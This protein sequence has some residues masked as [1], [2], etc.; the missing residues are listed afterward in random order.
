M[1][2]RFNY[3]SR[4]T[5]IVTI[6]IV[7]LL[8]LSA[9]GV[10][11]F[12]KGNDNAEAF[13]EN[14]TV[15]DG[16]SQAGSEENQTTQ[17]DEQ[18]IQPNID[19]QN[20]TTTENNE[21]GTT[22]N[23]TQNTT[24]QGT[25]NVSGGTT[26]STTA[27]TVPNNE[28]VT[29]RQEEVERLVAEDYLVGWTPISLAAI[30][31]NIE[32]N[33]DE[34]V[35][36][37]EI[38]KVAT[39]VN[40]E[41]IVKDEN[42]K[43]ETK[44]QKGDK[45]TYTITIRNTGNV[46]LQDINIS[47]E[48][49]NYSET[50]K[51]LA[52]GD[53]IV[54]TVE[55]TV[56]EQDMNEDEEIVN[57]V[58][59]T[60][61][62]QT[63]PDKTI[64]K[65][66]E[67]IVPVNPYI[68]VSG[69]KTWVDYDNKEN[70]RPETITVEILNG[71]DVVDTITVTAENGWKYTSKELPKY[72]AENNVIN[73][74]VREQSVDKYTTTVNDKNITNTLNYVPM[75]TISGE[76]T[77]VD[78]NNQENTRPEKITIEVLNGEKVV[79]TIIVTAENGWKYTSK[80]LP[81]YADKNA[82]TPIE[83]T[84]RESN[85]DAKYE[86][87]VDGNNIINTLKET[88]K[89]EITV[90]KVWSDGNNQDAN[91]PTSVKVQ[92][93]ADG[94]AQGNAITLTVNNKLQ[95]DENI[96]QYTFTG[97]DKY[98]SKN[99]KINYE[100]KEVI[101]S[102]KA[103]AENG[104]NGDYTVTYEKDSENKVMT[105]TNSYTPQTTEV[106]ATKVWVDNDNADQV[107]PGQITIKLYNG[108]TVVEKAPT[109]VKNGDTWT[110]TFKDLPKYAVGKLI[111]Y[112]AKELRA[113][114]T[115]V[116]NNEQ[117]NDDYVT[118]YN[119]NTITNTLV[120]PNITVVKTSNKTNAE[121]EYGTEIAYTLIATNSGNKA[122]NVTI[123]DTIPTGTELKEGSKIVV[124]VNGTT[125]NI[126]KAQLEAGYE[127]KGVAANNGNA[128]IT[129]TV[130]VKAYAGEKIENTAYY[131][132]DKD[133]DFTPTDEIKTNVEDK[134]TVIPT[135][136]ETTEVTTKQRAILVLD[137]SG[138]MNDSIKVS[139]KGWNAKYETKLKLM[140]NAVNTFLTEFLK[141]GKNE[142]MIITYSDDAKVTCGFTTNKT[143]AYNS[144]GSANGGTNIDAGLTLA[145]SKITSD[146]N[147]T[148]VILM[149]DGLPCYYVDNT[150]GERREEG[151]GTYYTKAPAE[152]AIESAG[153]IKAKG[154]KVYSIGFGLD[155]ITESEWVQDRY[156]NW[157][158]IG[159]NSREKAKELMQKIAS[160]TTTNSDGTQNKYYYDTYDG[161]ALNKAFK[162]IVSSI[163]TITNSDPISLKTTQGI[164]TITKGFKEGQKVEVYTGTY[165]KDTS[166]PVATYTW[167]EFV[168]LQY[169][170]Y[171]NNTITFNLGKYMKDSNI[172]ANT[173]VSLR[174]VNE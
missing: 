82:T 70:T 96:W 103:I 148:S 91:R 63:N 17:S 173:E 165:N 116:A 35:P 146:A 142:V 44:V 162:D 153:W 8:A 50:I 147:N 126:T 138:S 54:K 159:V 23:N 59:A 98:N 19:G 32:L 167:A 130:V 38:E 104:K 47:D 33:K 172:A 74:T 1:K 166:K 174:F 97:L 36:E 57:V 137:V 127:I 64:E 93:F 26:T 22:E 2:A 152:A 14:N 132:T 28:Y 21:Q 13:T 5:I 112:T 25:T 120:K 154:S 41:E 156:Y 39:L 53:E 4:K 107:R 164:V 106:I 109:V 31:S 42:G 81:K 34:L 3:K 102:G 30:T 85:V 143:I 122:G 29:E 129:F 100:V 149:T 40:G 101:S 11:V 15:I 9:T 89:T 133:T 99:E 128:T 79:D 75:V 157:I 161:D 51:V 92:L 87:T 76:K 113:D 111:T 114:G 80:E 168:T 88:P 90:S 68:T 135:I 73:Y 118:T 141:N 158:N 170:T 16:S 10:Y 123:K 12:T 124:K 84:V 27:P 61:T 94:I 131:K 121:V 52:I 66:D 105:I 77:W 115:I 108:N 20:G 58:K 55:Y 67:E 117:Y 95:A 48:L 69:E 37:F 119:G 144:I 24:G 65:E 134:A 46:T 45:V 71:N 155:S 43:V 160:P 145:N 56:N 163:T 78:Y 151:F 6:A 62:D 136:A 72:D 139:G 86:A 150:T 140:K 7:A 18:T 171:S 83:Y 60:V 125:T 49:I 110:Y 169:T